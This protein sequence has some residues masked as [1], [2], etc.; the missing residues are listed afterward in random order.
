MHQTR[1]LFRLFKSLNELNAMRNLMK[2]PGD[3][4][5]AYYFTIIH[6]FWELLHWICDNISTLAD[7]KLINADSTKFS[8]LGAKFRFVALVFSFLLTTRNFIHTAHKEM[9]I[10]KTLL[11][12]SENEMDAKKAELKL[13]RQKKLEIR[14]QLLRIFADFNVA[15]QVSGIGPKIFRI[16]FNEGF[17]CVCG[18]ISALIGCYSKY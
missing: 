2:T 9:T 6:M 5:F 4:E 7:I 10:E 18:I 13:V 17:I 8:V 16:K 3:D 12:C 11:T 1:R 15:G 14:L